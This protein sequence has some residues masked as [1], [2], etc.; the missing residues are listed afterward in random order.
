MKKEFFDF[1]HQVM[2][3]NPDVYFLMLGLGWPRVDEFL[4]KY[5]DRAFNFEASEQSAL[6]SCVGLAYAGKVA[7][8]YTITPFYWRAAETLRTYIAHENLS[9]ILVGVGRDDDYSAHDGY[10]HDAKDDWMLMKAA[11]IE[12][13]WKPESV[14]AM[15]LAL[16]SCIDIKKPAYI[17]IPR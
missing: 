7:V 13:T 17:N 9:V 10:S 15:Q 12:G 6:D 16:K 1:M 5:P 2:E 14:P 4:E 3:E 11:G 8:I